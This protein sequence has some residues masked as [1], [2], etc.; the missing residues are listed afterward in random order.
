LNKPSIEAVDHGKILQSMLGW[1][2]VLRG[3]PRLEYAFP[4]F[5]DNYKTARRALFWA[6]VAVKR[7]GFHDYAENATEWSKRVSGELECVL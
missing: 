5:M 7:I 4:M 1:E 6:M 2:T 3:T